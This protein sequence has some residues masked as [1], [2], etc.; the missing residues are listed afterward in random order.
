VSVTTCPEASVDGTALV[1]A[2]RGV[3]DE[4]PPIWLMRQAGRHLPEYRA[5]RSQQGSF[6]DF[7]YAPA[8]A[9]EATL[10][11]TRRYGVSAAIIFSDILVIPDALGRAVRFVEGEGPRLD[12]ITTGDE[13]DA[14]DPVRLPGHLAPVYEA[15][16]R[17]RGQL[18]RDRAL[19]GFAGAPW[20]L[21][22]YMIQGKG[23]DRQTARAFA[24]A[25]PAL[26]DRLL[27]V[28]ADATGDH[29]IA[30]VRAGADAVQIFES[31]AE[32]VP[33]TVFQR[34]IAAPAARVVE[35]FR[36]ACPD[37]PVIGF[38]RGA[39]HRVGQYQRATGVDAVGLGIAADIA[40]ARAAV[41]PGVCLQG[42]L[43][44]IVLATGGGALD[45]AVDAILAATA[46]TPH[47][48]NLGHGVVPHTPIA[49]VERL[50]R[51]VSG[52]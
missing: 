38:P 26:T 14:L 32:D 11:P 35:R 23:G 16:A 42:N 36:A 46:G 28:L 30:Q 4:R 19:I 3:V 1:R 5:L 22:T 10:Q 25:N 18:E 21:A 43:D 24:Y 33:E 13:V 40:A 50:V 41:G 48:F 15:V 7:C 9:A 8:A 27:A 20:T 17:V 29:L 12:P 34:W 52:L 6:L 47:V 39:S 37:V 2:L 51:R 31:W 45:E 44:P 49:H